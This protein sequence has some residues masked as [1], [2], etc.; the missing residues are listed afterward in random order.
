MAPAAQVLFLSHGGGPLPLLGDPAHGEMVACLQALAPQ[1]RRPAAILVISAHWEAEVPTLTAGAHPPLIYDY[2]GFPEASYAITYPCPGDPALAQ[3]LAAGLEAG[4]ASARLDAGRGFDHGLFVPLKLLF[5]EATIP[6]V[7]LSLLRSLDAGAHLALGHQL[8]ALQPSLAE[9][10]VLVIG[11]GFTFHNM[12]EF[13]RAS[14]PESTALN[15][16]FEAWLLDTCSN[17]ALSEPEREQRLLHWSQAPGARHCHPREEHLLPLH[18]CYGL[19][20]RP[21]SQH[22]ELQILQ[23]HTSMYLWS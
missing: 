4:G 14:S 20:G 21:C 18:V 12:R 22:V 1:L 7:Q 6:C 10:N 15:R 8:R 17:P 3:Q 2:T 9:Q 16:A 11:S 19:A 23:K 5:P 13:F